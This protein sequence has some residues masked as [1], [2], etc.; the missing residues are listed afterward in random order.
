MGLH[1]IARQSSANFDI[2]RVG[3]SLA[4]VSNGSSGVPSDTEVYI[5]NLNSG[6]SPGTQWFSEPLCFYS[7]GN[8]LNLTLLETRVTALI[9][10]FA[11]AIP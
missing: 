6:G 5:F 7:V 8:F 4:N 10:A 3:T 9:N 11:A 1:G 2:K